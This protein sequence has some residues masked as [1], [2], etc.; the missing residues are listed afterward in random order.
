[1]KEYKTMTVTG[2]GCMET[3]SDED[4]TPYLYAFITNINAGYLSHYFNI[5]T[6]K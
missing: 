5:V 2:V 1:M 3:K 6:N 4:I